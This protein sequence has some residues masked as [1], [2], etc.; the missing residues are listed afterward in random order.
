MRQPCVLRRANT[1]FEF[2]H[3]CLAFQDCGQKAGSISSNVSLTELVSIFSDR[4]WPT[5]RVYKFAPSPGHEPSI[6]LGHFSDAAHVL[7][8]T[9]FRQLLSL[10][11]SANLTMLPEPSFL[12]SP[13]VHATQM[14]EGN[15]YNLLHIVFAQNWNSFNL[16]NFTL[17]DLA[18]VLHFKFRKRID[19]GGLKN[20]ARGSYAQMI[21]GYPRPVGE[22][23]VWHTNIWPNLCNQLFSLDGNDHPGG[24][25]GTDGRE[26]ADLAG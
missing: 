7:Y 16:I 19:N 23:C 11:T 25:F 18:E 14:W 5:T 26:P 22:F 20:A 2:C 10:P 6:P 4:E 9:M 3:S 13:P 1:D 8:R 21:N 17:L 12:R 24:D 15:Y